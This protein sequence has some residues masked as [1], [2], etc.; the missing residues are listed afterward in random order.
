MEEKL[1]KYYFYYLIDDDKTEL[2]AYTDNKKISEEFKLQ[3]NMNKFI[4]KKEKISRE[5][6]NKLATDIP[7][8]YLEVVD[9]ITE[10]RG[11]G[12]PIEKIS[13]AMT[14]LETMS[15]ISTSNDIIYS[16]IWG[17]TYINPFIFKNDILFALQRIYYVNGYMTYFNKNDLELD[18][19]DVDVYNDFDFDLFNTFVYL[20][21]DTLAIK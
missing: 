12:S 19:F 3:R 2:Y 11:H 6:L 16:K 13:I 1:Y 14:R 17:N 15:V 10:K 5:E 21:G 18:V 7:D 4:Y 8:L 20:Y 9:G